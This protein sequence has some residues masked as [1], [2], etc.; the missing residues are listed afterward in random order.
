ML[1]T[2]NELK[3]EVDRPR[4]GPPQS[5]TTEQPSLRSL[6]LCVSDFA[7]LEVCP[8]PPTRLFAA[9]WAGGR[10]I[11]GGAIFSGLREIFL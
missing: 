11:F 10:G 3:D 8:V 4:A 2:T 5:R 9:W 1:C 7:I 6:R